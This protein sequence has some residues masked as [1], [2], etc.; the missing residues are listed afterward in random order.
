[1]SLSKLKISG[2]TPEP[3]YDGQVTVPSDGPGLRAQVEGNQG[4]HA[5]DILLVFLNDKRV[6]IHTITAVEVQNGVSFY[7]EKAYVV[8]GD[9]IVKY[10]IINSEN[11]TPFDSL[12]LKLKVIPAEE[13]TEVVFASQ[14]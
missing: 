9:A 13:E 10:T 3:D 11:G 7:I 5:E 1:M 14:R 2:V 12:E 6:F 4:Y 8:P